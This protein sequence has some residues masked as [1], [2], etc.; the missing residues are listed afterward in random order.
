M[1]IHSIMQ[2]PTNNEFLPA[3]DLRPLSHLFFPPLPSHRHFFLFFFL[4]FE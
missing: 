3:R 4:K 1:C 2:I